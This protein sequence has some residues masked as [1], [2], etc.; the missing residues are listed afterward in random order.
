MTN[1]QKLALLAALLALAF[2]GSWD[3]WSFA[4]IAGVGAFEM[5]CGCGCGGCS[6]CCDG[7]PYPDQLKITVAGVSG[8]YCFDGD[9]T[10]WNGDFYADRDDAAGAFCPLTSGTVQFCR[11]ITPAFEACEI[12]Q[13][14]TFIVEVYHQDSG[15]E[16][17]IK[18]ALD[19]FGL[20]VAAW[21]LV[22]ASICPEDFPLT[23]TF[24][25]CAGAQTGATCDFPATITVDLP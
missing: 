19:H 18:V 1:R 7:D 25:T 15:D 13:T 6:V 16:C 5:G 11:W 10:D 8:S 21:K 2:F 24:D 20:Q 12:S 3:A 17:G 14:T 22:S 9:C 23:L 4:I